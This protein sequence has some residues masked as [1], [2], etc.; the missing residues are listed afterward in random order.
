MIY[1]GEHIYIWQNTAL[2]ILYLL[3]FIETMCMSKSLEKLTRTCRN[4]L[5]TFSAMVFC[6]SNL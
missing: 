3:A 1:I 6:L 4:G 5:Q 2:L